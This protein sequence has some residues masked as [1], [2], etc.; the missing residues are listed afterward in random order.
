MTPRNLT[1]STSLICVESILMSSW[2]LILALEK[3]TATVLDIEILKPQRSHHFD[4]LSRVL[5]MMALRNLIFLELR[6]IAVSSAKREASVLIRSLVKSFII[7]I[8]NNG[9]MTDP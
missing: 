2:S 5:F 9:D 7:I 8:N 6:K 3:Q 1:F 4:I